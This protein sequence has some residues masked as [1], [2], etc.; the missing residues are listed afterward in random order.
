MPSLQED[1]GLHRLE[2][3]YGVSALE[4]AVLSGSVAI[5]E[6]LIEKCQTAGEKQQ[7]VERAMLFAIKENDLSMMDRLIDMHQEI[8]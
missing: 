8:G 6:K 3:N 7:A 5:V 4:H 1:P 2:D